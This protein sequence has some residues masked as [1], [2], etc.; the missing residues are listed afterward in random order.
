MQSI[1]LE[2]LRALRA[3]AESKTKVKRPTR[4][5]ND[6]EGQEQTKVFNWLDGEEQRRSEYAGLNSVTYHVPN[7]GQRN[8]AVAAKLKAQGTKAGIVDIF[9]DLARGGFYGLR[10]EMKATAPNNSNLSARQ[11][12]R[13]KIMEREGY[14]VLLC[15]GYEQ[16]VN[17]LKAYYRWP[18][19]ENCSVKMH[20]EKEK[21]G[22]NWYEYPV[23]KERVKSRR[24]KR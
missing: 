23:D 10:I 21:L 14:C 16:T 20:D 8:G 11:F 13:M 2:E 22:T 7:G 3:S 5:M 19:T 18:L 24:K 12:E 1:S 9:C 15:V 17:A 6:Y 4:H